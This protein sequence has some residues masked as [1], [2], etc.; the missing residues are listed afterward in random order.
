[1][2]P[3]LGACSNAVVTANDLAAMDAIGYNLNFDILQN[4]GYAISTAQIAAVP[5][6]MTWSLMILGFGLIGGTMRR[7]ST[8][9]A[10]AI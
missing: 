8:K 6:P 4:K 3:T 1:M 10:F 9:V 2:D 5:E 7:R